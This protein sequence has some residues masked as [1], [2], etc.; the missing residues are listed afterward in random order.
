MSKASCKENRE[1]TVAITLNRKHAAELRK[2]GNRAGGEVKKI[3]L[4]GLVG[5]QEAIV[6]LVRMQGRHQ[7]KCDECRKRK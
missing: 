3:L 5:C 6:R 2:A 4:G 1:F 7:K